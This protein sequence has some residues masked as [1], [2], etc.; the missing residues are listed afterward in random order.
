MEADKTA[1]SSYLIDKNHMTHQPQKASVVQANPN[2][3]RSKETHNAISTLTEPRHQSAFDPLNA[4]AHDHRPTTS[5]RLISSASSRLIQDDSRVCVVQPAPSV[6]LSRTPGKDCRADANPRC[7]TGT[8]RDPVAGMFESI[9][10]QELEMLRMRW[11]S[12]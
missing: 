11:D 6:S 1:R 3:K 5:S 10:T 8:A 4:N 7:D 2:R 9:R 12:G